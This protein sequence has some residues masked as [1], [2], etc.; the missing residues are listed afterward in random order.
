ML[1]TI[2]SRRLPKAPQRRAPHAQ[3]RSS[4]AGTTPSDAANS[5]SAQEVARNVNQRAGLCDGAQR[6]AAKFSSSGDGTRTRDSRIMNPV[7]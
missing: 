4:D 5:T 2:Y 1:R 3:I 7:L 6:D